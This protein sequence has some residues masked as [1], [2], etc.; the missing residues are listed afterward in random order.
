MKPGA[1]TRSGLPA[2]RRPVTVG[3]LIALSVAGSF[4]KIPSVIGTPALDAL[5]GYFA[6]AALG[7]PEGALVAA[8][9][10]L[11]TAATAGFPLSPGVHVLV[12]CL[13]AGAVVA[14]GAVARKG[15]PAGA[16]PLAMVANGV[17][18]PA[19]LL[20]I[21]GFGT[22]FFVAVVPSLIVASGINAGL[23]ALLY[24]SYRRNPWL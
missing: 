13:T 3:L 12:A 5:P 19:V 9:G 4:V 2:A 6:A 1:R 16:V 15:S 21:P 8:F 22:A 18:A 24:H 11:A 20:L 14:F 10:H 7:L 17:L 23:A